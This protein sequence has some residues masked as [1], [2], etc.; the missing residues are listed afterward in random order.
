M[1]HATLALSRLSTGSITLTI[2]AV[3]RKAHVVAILK[4]KKPAEDAKSYR[5]LSLL[6]IPYKLMERIILARINVIVEANLPQAQAGFRKG[7]ST[8]DQTVRL[9]NDI[10]AAFQKKAKVGVAYIHLYRC[11]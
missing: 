1:P 2:P 6:C 7:R 4:P 8:T 5:P 3:W 10:E 9:V 11:L